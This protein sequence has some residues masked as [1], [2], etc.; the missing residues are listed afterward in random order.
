[1]QKGNFPFSAKFEEKKSSYPRFEAKNEGVKPKIQKK[2]TTKS[3]I[4]YFLFFS[5]K[6]KK[7]LQSSTLYK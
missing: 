2:K 3:K 1:M 5:R 7:A 4:T 6:C